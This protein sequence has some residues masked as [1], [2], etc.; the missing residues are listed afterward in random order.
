MAVT[1]SYINTP[2]L[3]SLAEN[4]INVQVASS[5]TGKTNLYIHLAILQYV[6][7]AWVSAGFEDAIP[8][9]NGA[10]Q[11]D[12]S[13]Y[14]SAVLS[15]KFTYPEHYTNVAIPQPIMVVKYRIKVWET[16]IDTDG[17]RVD[18]SVADSLTNSAD[19]FVVPGGI[20]E[21]DEAI[22]NTLSSNWWDE[23]ITQ[24]KFQQWMPG[25]KTT[26]IK[27]VE[28]LYWIARRSAT[29]TITFAWIATDGTTGSV[30]ATAAMTAYMM[31]ELC[32]SPAIAEQLSGKE[33]ASYTV[34]ITGQSETIGYTI[35]R[36]YYET[37]EFFLMANGF[38]C[39]E[40]LWCK[41]YRQGEMQFDRVQYE[42]ALNTNFL[43]TDR[44]FGSTRAKITR[45]RKSNT[46]AFDDEDWYNWAL[47]LLA[48]ED[49]WIYGDN[50]IAP[51]VITSEK[52]TYKDDLNDLWYLEFEWKYSREGIFGGSLGLT[53]EY[54]LP[55]YY[56]RLAA[57]FSL[58]VNG[59]LVDAIAGLTAT[60]DGTII[61]WPNIAAS[62]VLDFSDATFWNSSLVT[63][64]DVA[65]PRTVP[66][67]FMQG[68]TWAEAATVTTHAR[69]FHKDYN[70]KLRDLLPV[71]VYASDLTTAEQVIVVAW[72]DWYQVI[73]QNGA[74]LKQE[75]NSI[76]TS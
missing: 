54:M 27:S 19:L 59:V 68:G 33:L 3:V 38:N 76:K 2:S 24:K 23:W 70:S 51:V 58:I 10:A 44:R 18:K 57:F 64:Y 42:Q 74:I 46:N 43:H 37:E 39:Y 31:Y 45:S 48:G 17:T 65:T 28:K 25:E 52:L 69:L 50:M 5:V 32:V 29:E 4:Q 36:E 14:F 16:Y 26:S 35:D 8:A 47:S 72:L 66:L 67:T 55:P 7:S 13:A 22:L 71:L 53:I 56:S 63:G 6:N 40:S 11:F 9:I 49:A 75:N 41:A 1:V 21:D 61:T 62:D 15:Q 73:T 60:V 30:T 34:T 20:S 12:I